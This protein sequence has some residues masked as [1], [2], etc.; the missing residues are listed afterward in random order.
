MKSCLFCQ[1]IAWD[2]PCYKVYEDEHVIAFLDIYP[3][4]KYHT[5]IVPKQHSLNIYDI[6]TKDLHAILFA[7]KKI[8]SLYKEK[9]WIENI[10]IHSNNWTQAQ[11][12]IGHSHWHIIPRSSD[13][14]LDIK[15]TTHPERQDEFPQMLEKL[16]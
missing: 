15:R 8:T 5:L 6:E 1:I 12:E 13:D 10:Q 16:R 9:L 11:Q 7:T 3:N 2:I 4:S 14:D